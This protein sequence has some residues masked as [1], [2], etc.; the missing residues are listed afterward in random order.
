LQTTRLFR[1]GL[2]AF[3]PPLPSLVA[4]SDSLMSP[5]NIVGASDNTGTKMTA[6]QKFSE[7]FRQ[8]RKLL[9][10]IEHPSTGVWTDQGLTSSHS[11]AIYGT[12]G[13]LTAVFIV[14]VSFSGEPITLTLSYQWPRITGYL[15]FF[16]TV[17]PGLLF[18]KRWKKKYGNNPDGG[19][20]FLWMLATVMT[21]LTAGHL[22]L[23]GLSSYMPLLEGEELKFYEFL[24]PYLTYLPEYLMT[25]LVVSM[26]L[27]YFKV[28]KW[29]RRLDEEKLKREAAEHGQA[30]AQAQLKLL[31]AQI[32]P[33][34]LF[35][36]LAS[37]QHLV[38]KD[39]PRADFLLSQL[40]RYLREAMPDIRG[41]GSTMGREFGLVE[42]YLNIVRIRLDGRLEIKVNIPPELADISFPALIVQ[43]L[44]EN[45][46]KHG[47]EPKPGPVNIYVTASEA[48]IEGKK[49]IDV[50]VSDDGVGFGVAET[51]GSGIGLRNIR[52]RLAGLYGPSARLDITNA[53]PSGVRATVRIPGRI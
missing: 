31:Q 35:N 17:G 46:I 40:I 20:I 45:A 41:M 49:F 39:P 34:F 24:K 16:A 50:C 33:H 53:M 12:F 1:H 5:A 47:I 14:A 26:S 19:V 36:T 10:E 29:Q 51:M 23:W 4:L 18:A 37:V 7:A 44:V 22:T 21:G 15:C 52:E 32:E 13:A 27:R 30:L 6:M 3:V 48:T 43:T 38:R 42:A 28:G 9:N 2:A 8:W 11:R 25:A